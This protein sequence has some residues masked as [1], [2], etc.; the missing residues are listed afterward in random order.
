VVISQCDSSCQ[1]QR[2]NKFYIDGK[3]GGIDGWIN[4]VPT[5]VKSA[6]TK[7]VSIKASQN[8]RDRQALAELNSPAAIEEKRFISDLRIA[9]Y[10]NQGDPDVDA[11]VWWAESRRAVRRILKEA[12]LQTRPKATLFLHLHYPFF[13]DMVQAILMERHPNNCPKV[14]PWYSVNAYLLAEQYALTALS[15]DPFGQIEFYL[16][17]GAAHFLFINDLKWFSHLLIA[18]TD[19]VAIFHN[20]TIP[21]LPFWSLKLQGWNN[22]FPEGTKRPERWLEGTEYLAACKEYNLKH[23]DKNRTS[24]ITVSASRET[25]RRKKIFKIW[26]PCWQSNLQ[27][28]DTLLNAPSTKH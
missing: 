7:R 17:S 6:K 25:G 23:P 9:S 19:A 15:D 1:L 14:E 8:K 24:S 22:R 5:M 27:R 21:D 4:H 12:G 3:S 10:Q 16:I 13:D 11:R 2:N 26:L 18:M 28:L 20:N